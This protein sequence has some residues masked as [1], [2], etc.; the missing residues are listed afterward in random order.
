MST[1]SAADFVFHAALKETAEQDRRARAVA[2]AVAVIEAKASATDST[3]LKAEF[4][5]LSEYADAIQKALL[6]S[7][8]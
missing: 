4:S 2:A 7:E 6:V 5:R 1:A 8:E 3:N